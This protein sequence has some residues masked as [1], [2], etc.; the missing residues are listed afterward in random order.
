MVLK[1]E[2]TNKKKALTNIAIPL[3]RDNLVG[4]LTLYAINKLERISRKGAV[5]AEKGFALFISNEDTNDIIK[6][7]KSL[8]DSDILIDGVTETVKHE[9]KNKNVDFLKLC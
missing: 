2:S 4:N 1:K 7:K 3:T 8:E 6:I 9:I 5:R